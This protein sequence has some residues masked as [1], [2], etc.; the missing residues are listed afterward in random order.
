MA[1]T[2]ETADDLNFGERLVKKA[3]AIAKLGRRWLEADAVNA[4]AKVFDTP[5]ASNDDRL[6]AERLYEEAAAAKAEVEEEYA[7]LLKTLK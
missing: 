4:Q 7:F 2:D 3:S 1:G 5:F 6:E